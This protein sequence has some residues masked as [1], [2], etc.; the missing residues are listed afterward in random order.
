MGELL[1]R[2]AD[3][4]IAEQ[5]RAY[6]ECLNTLFKELSQRGIICDARLD[7]HGDYEIV[8]CEIEIEKIYRQ[9]IEKV[10]Y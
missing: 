2:M 5:V 8:R 3:K 4:E 9:K 7:F 10:E 6:A 1:N